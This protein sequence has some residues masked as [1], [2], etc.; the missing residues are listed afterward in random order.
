[1]NPWGTQQVQVRRT[2]DNAILQTTS[3]SEIGF[4]TAANTVYVV[5]RTAKP[6]SAY[7]SVQLTGSAN[8]GVK[9]LR[10]TASTLGTGGGTGGGLVNDTA[11]TYDA[12]WFLT[13][14]RGYGDY[15]DDTHHS[16]T[17]GNAANYTFTG[18]GVEYLSERFSDMGNVDVYIDGTFQANVNLFVSGAR[19]AQQVVYSKT[20][21][22]SGTHTI[23]IVNKS[24]AV[25]MVDALRIITSGPPASFTAL[26]AR[27]NNQYVSA[28]NAGAGSLIANAAAIGTWERFDVIDLGGGNVGLRAQINGRYV[29]AENAGAAALIAN[30]TAIGPWETFRMVVNANGTVSFLAQAN[31]MYV[32]AE[33]A[34]A[35][36]LIANRAAIG[37]WEQFDRV[38]P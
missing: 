15:N 24:T 36:P 16:T 25:G 28:A 7:T 38:V 9:T 19:Q 1:V 18:T 13:T 14:G 3:A 17:V 34:G 23:R 29:C 30:R 5:E 33:N 37:G 6:L 11:L 35:A 32:T 20:G 27:A 4:A 8:Q 2:S 12:G 10:N 21:L 26:R 22:P 31:G